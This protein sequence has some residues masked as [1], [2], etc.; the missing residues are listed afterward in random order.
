[1]LIQQQW[2]NWLFLGLL[3]LIIYTVSANNITVL[4]YNRE[5]IIDGEY[6]RL[7]SGNFNHTNIY[8]LILNLGALAV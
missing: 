1:M 5:L 3:C 4:D 7:L 2:L 8:H 6:W